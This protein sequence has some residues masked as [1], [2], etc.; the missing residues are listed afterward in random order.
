MELGVLILNTFEA[1]GVILVFVTLLFS[2]KYPVVVEILEL[3][4]PEGE[5]AKKRFKSRLKRSIV[6]DCLPVLF[7]AATSFYVLLPLAVEILCRGKISLWG[8][9]MLP[10]AYLI[11]TLWLFVLTIW[12]VFLTY[13]VIRK[14]RGIRLDEPA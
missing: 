10:L 7:L 12:T 3:E 2:M 9:D 11:I 5:K 4:C 8:L 6:T 13:K 1:I 14:I